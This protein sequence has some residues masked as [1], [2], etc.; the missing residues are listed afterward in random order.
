MTSP[1]PKFRIFASPHGP[2]SH[3][4]SPTNKVVCAAIIRNNPTFLSPA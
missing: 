2:V 4:Y 1:N 3:R